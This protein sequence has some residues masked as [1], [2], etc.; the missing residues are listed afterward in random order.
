MV[1][2]YWSCPEIEN[3]KNV[4]LFPKS[5]SARSSAEEKVKDF[6]I[7]SESLVIILRL[8]EIDRSADIYI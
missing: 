6:A 5:D 4:I 2:D 7:K 1:Q 3:E 8:A